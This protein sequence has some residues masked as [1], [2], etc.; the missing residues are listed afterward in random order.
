[1]IDQRRNR[2][3]VTRLCALLAVAKSGYQVW[4]AGKAVSPR[5]LEDERLLV[6][7]KAAHQRSR[8]KYGPKKIKDEWPIKGS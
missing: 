1:M 3:P 2:H 6:V 7:I 8:G 4:S 5:R